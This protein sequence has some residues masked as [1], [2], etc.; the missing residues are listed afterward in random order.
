MSGG[1]LLGGVGSLLGKTIRAPLTA[2]G[3]TPELP[4][5]PEAPDPTELAEEEAEAVATGR[6]RALRR[7]ARRQNNATSIL[8]GPLG[9]PLANL[10]LGTATLLGQ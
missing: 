1:G 5:V 2:L 9:Q 8:T 4:P 3:L 6:D 10:Q 7:A